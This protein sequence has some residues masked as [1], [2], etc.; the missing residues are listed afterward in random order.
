MTAN[1]ANTIFIIIRV[2]G[3]V[4]LLTIFTTQF[5]AA[6]REPR[7]IRSS[8]YEALRYLTKVVS[9]T[10]DSVLITMLAPKGSWLVTGTKVACNIRKIFF[11]KLSSS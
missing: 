11:S 7:Q 8:D 6:S 1:T 4:L 5:C 9:V 10:R 2:I 3:G